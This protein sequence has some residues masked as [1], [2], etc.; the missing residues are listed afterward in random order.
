MFKVFLVKKVILEFTNTPPPR[1]YL[2]VACIIIIIIV[3]GKRKYF[4]YQ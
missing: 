3:F 1:S 4:T 2:S